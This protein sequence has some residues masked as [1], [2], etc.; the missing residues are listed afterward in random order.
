MPRTDAQQK[1]H[2]SPWLSKPKPVVAGEHLMLE[3]GSESVGMRSR[4][5]TLISQIHP[6]SFNHIVANTERVTFH[7]NPHYEARVDWVKTD[8]ST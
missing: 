5:M 1:L 7:A 8:F 3:D 6:R 4:N 2:T